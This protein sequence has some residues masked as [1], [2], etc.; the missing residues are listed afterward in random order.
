MAAT[1]IVYLIYSGLVIVFSF[2]IGYGFKILQE[3]PVNIPSMLLA[4][5]GTG[6][7]VLGFLSYLDQI[8]DKITSYR[9][10][11]RVKRTLLIEGEEI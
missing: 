10:R 5:I 8:I 11:R 1:Y 3:Q 7:L 9:R 6:L 2:V 4:G